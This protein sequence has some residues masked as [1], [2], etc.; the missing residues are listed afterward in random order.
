MKRKYT[1][2]LVVIFLLLCAIFA[3]SCAPKFNSDNPPWDT[4]FEAEGEHPC[5]FVLIDQNGK[6]VRLYDFYGKVIIL[7]FST[8]WCG[9][10]RIAALGV[11]PMIEK[12]GEENIAYITILIDNSFGKEPDLRDLQYWA[13]QNGI[14]NGPVLGGS[15]DFITNGGWDITSWPTFFFIDQTMVL[16]TVT[17]GY[18]AS[19]IDSTISDLVGES[20]IVV[21]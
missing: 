19:S 13:N 14:V 15:R 9:P 17:R 11:D 7:D 1:I 4:C 12:Y 16:R 8:M 6:E 2:R 5:D 10:C 3:S 18:N 21:E 20:S